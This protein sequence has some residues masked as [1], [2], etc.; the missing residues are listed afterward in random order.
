MTIQHDYAIELEPFK[1]T[2][3]DRGSKKVMVNGQQWG[4]IY[5]TSHGCNGPLY[6]LHDMHSEVTRPADGSRSGRAARIPVTIRTENGR[7]ARI[8]L[9]GTD[10]KPQPTETV[11][12]KMVRD[13]IVAKHLRSPAERE[14][15]IEDAHARH[16]NAVEAQDRDA[17]R[18]LKER[19]RKVMQNGECL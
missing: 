3:W 1:R 19:A 10:Q 12:E 13:A 9:V 2:A 11:L 7:H 15:E 18:R 16:R 8:R 17:D 14:Q 4:W 6:H 5:M